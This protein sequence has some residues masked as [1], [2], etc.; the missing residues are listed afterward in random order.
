MK[1]KL[2]FDRK[3]QAKAIFGVISPFANGMTLTEAHSAP[4]LTFVLFKKNFGEIYVT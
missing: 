4:L 2:S 1:D 3:E